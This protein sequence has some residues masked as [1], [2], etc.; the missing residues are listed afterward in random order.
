MVYNVRWNNSTRGFHIFK[1]ERWLT[2]FLTKEN[3]KTIV[4]LSHLTNY[5]SHIFRQIIK[6]LCPTQQWQPL[7]ILFFSSKLC[8]LIK[9][10]YDIRN[11]NNFPTW[12]LDPTLISP[13]VVASLFAFGKIC[14]D[15]LQFH[16]QII[17]ILY[18][19]IIHC[20]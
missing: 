7:Q 4:E 8:S 9:N 6:Y 5:F 15:C 20:S 3:V 14:Y 19:M 2:D 10:K 1:S 12:W 16:H 13:C 11:Y 18:I 17:N